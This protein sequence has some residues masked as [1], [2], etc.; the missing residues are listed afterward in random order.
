MSPFRELLKHNSRFYWDDTLEQL[1]Q[2]SKET[3]LENIRDGVR[4]FEINRPTCLTTDW[5]RTGIGFTL[6]QKHCACPSTMD[7]RC[8]P[9]HWKVVYAGSRFTRPAENRYAPIEGEALAIKFGLESCK[10]FLFRLP[11]PDTCY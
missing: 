9:G 1:F 3:I 4:T 11:P 7:H 6:L 5:S 8:G 2:Q 10:M